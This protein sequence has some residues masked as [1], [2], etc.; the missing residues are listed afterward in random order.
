MYLI[1]II[2]T[3]IFIPYSIFVIS[4]QT[5]NIYNALPLIILYI[6]MLVT[7]N[8]TN[9]HNNKQEYCTIITFEDDNNLTIE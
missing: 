1:N 2:S 9:K 5:I 8:R 4:S 6:V 7:A 3:V